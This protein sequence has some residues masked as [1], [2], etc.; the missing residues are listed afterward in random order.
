[1]IIHTISSSSVAAAPSLS[2][3]D[4]FHRLNAKN[5]DR[6][7]DEFYS[8]EKFEF[9]DPVVH[10]HSREEMK[11]YYQHQYDEVKSI[12]FDFHEVVKE[13]SVTTAS[14]TMF[15]SHPK[16]KGGKEISV[17]GVSLFKYDSSSERKVM[18]HRDYFDMGEFVYENIPVMGSLIRFIKK[19]MGEVQ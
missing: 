12:R 14:W 15:L 4:F 10:L 18:Y 16:I 9:T 11:K 17:E 6:L 5:V 3:Q 8:T 19:K 7:V 2:V 13:G 1:M